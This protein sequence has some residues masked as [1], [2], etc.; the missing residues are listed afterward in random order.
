MVIWWNKGAR[1]F[2]RGE[3]LGVIAARLVQVGDCSVVSA[4]VDALRDLR[5]NYLVSLV[6]VVV[7]VHI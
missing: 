3:R 6:S 1:Q 7:W 5:R 2:L 4:P